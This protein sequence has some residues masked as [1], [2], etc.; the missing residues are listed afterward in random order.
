MKQF[1]E[2]ITAEPPYYVHKAGYLYVLGTPED[3]QA[4][5]AD[6]WEQIS[7]GKYVRINAKNLRGH[8]TNWK[9]EKGTGQIYSFVVQCVVEQDD[10]LLLYEEAE[11]DF[12]TSYYVIAPKKWPVEL[13]DLI[14]YEHDDF[15]GD[16]QRHGWVYGAFSWSEE[17]STAQTSQ[18]GGDPNV[19]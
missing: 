8:L 4:A 15:K 1:N 6:G 18:E 10:R 9:A 5:I 2:T 16:D 3:L 13:G 7:E 11:P 14:Q 17:V 12:E 19:P